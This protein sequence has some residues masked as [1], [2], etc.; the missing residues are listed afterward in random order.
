[1]RERE[2]ERQERGGWGG[3]NSDL[4]TDEVIQ[5][6]LYRGAN[7]ITLLSFHLVFNKS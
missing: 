6:G 4:S 3:A 1:M 5:H 7:D 2:R